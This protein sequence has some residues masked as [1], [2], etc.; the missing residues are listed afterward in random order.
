MGRRD[1]AFGS[2]LRLGDTGRSSQNLNPSRHRL[3]LVTPHRS[4]SVQPRTRDTDGRHRRSEE[5]RVGKE[6][7][8][9]CRSRWSPNTKKK[10]KQLVK[11]KHMKLVVTNKTTH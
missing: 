11:H 6:C 5:R 4:N 1:G 10:Q 2:R 3:N 9:T 7:V 8:S